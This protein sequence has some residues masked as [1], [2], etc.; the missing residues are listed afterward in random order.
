MASGIFKLPGV[1]FITGAGGSGIGASISRGFVRA[2]CS[3]MALTDIKSL[4]QTKEMILKI[5]PKAQVLT[6]RGDIA[7]ESFVASFTEEIIKNF[8]RLDYN[9]NCAGILGESLRSHEMPIAD[10]DRVININLKGTWLASR[11]AL[12]QMVKQEPLNHPGQKGA[13]VNIA[14]QLGI[15]GRPA[16]APYCASKAAIINMTRADAIDYS[17]D[18]IR[19]NCVCP[20]LIESP[21]T[22]AS[23]EAKERLRSAVKVAPMER[24]GTPEEVANAILFL[25][26]SHASFIQG[27]ALVVDGG[28]TI[29]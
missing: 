27:H 1:A 25:C 8:Y 7:D 12:S 11:A 24:M 16:A 15:V 2:G 18:G 3:R 10:F 20:G 9:V 26:S 22:T 4:A 17:H 29:N 13:I 6:K 19:V 23:H 14:S 28:Y 5:N 21:M